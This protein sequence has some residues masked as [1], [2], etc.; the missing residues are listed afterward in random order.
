MIE[1]LKG[2]LPKAKF[3]RESA[4]IPFGD[5]DAI[6]ALFEACENIIARGLLGRTERRS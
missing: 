5:R 4:K 1:E 2:I 6:P 3:G